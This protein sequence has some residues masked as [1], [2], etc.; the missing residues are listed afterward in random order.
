VKANAEGVSNGD[1]TNALGLQSD[2]Q[3]GS[4]NYLAY[5]ILGLLLREGLIT[6]VGVRN[7]QRHV[8]TS[9]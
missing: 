4:I 5:S 8:A 9:G 3:G 2:Y 1:V 6:R 7:A